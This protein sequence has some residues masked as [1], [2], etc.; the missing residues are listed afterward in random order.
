MKTQQKQSA[1]KAKDKD[2]ASDKTHSF[3]AKRQ[4]FL[5][6]LLQSSQ[7]YSNEAQLASEESSA[8]RSS[9]RDCSAKAKSLARIVL[10]FDLA[11]VGESL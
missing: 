11:F 10:C 7:L 6:A 2:S 8:K 4:T 9:F 3:R 5:F 1:A